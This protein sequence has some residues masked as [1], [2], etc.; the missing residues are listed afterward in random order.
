MSERGDT[1]VPTGRW[2][3]DDFPSWLSPMLVR[4][5]RQGV[6]SGGFAWTFVVLQGLMFLLM[7]WAVTNLGANPGSGISTF[8]NVV[9]WL[10][11]AAVM[12]FIVPLRALTSVSSERPGNNLDLVRLTRLSATRIILAGLQRDLS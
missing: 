12:A 1:V 11:V 2:R 9:F 7:S 5:L 8:F 10:M 3:G 6:Q 4:E